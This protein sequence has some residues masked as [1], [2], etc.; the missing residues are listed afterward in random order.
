[1]QKHRTAGQSSVE[2]KLD[3]SESLTSLPRSERLTHFSRHR[4][5]RKIEAGAYVAKEL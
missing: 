4:L 2:R 1:M 5:Q 3:V